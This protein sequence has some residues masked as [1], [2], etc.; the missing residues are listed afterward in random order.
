[1]M[2]TC[3]ILGNINNETYIMKDFF[4]IAISVM[5]YIIFAIMSLTMDAK[6]FPEGI[7]V[8]FTTFLISYYT[9]HATKQI[10]V[11][12]ILF[13][14]FFIITGSLL[15]LHEV[16]YG[17]WENCRKSLFSTGSLYM[18][19]QLIPLFCGIIIG[20]LVKM[21]KINKEHTRFQSSKHQF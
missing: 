9:I 6:L 3:Y 4:R 14:I 1:M 15:T 16:D 5:L 7:L 18:M 2:I 17:F 10:Y 20:G 11:H 12:M 8:C 19:V 13:Y 21:Y